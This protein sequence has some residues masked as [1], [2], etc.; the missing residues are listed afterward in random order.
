MPSIK[1][2][3]SFPSVYD[4]FSSMLDDLGLVQMV[5]E[6]I[7]CGN[8]LDLFLTSN[9]SL[10]QKVEFV[11]GIADHDIM[12]ANVNVKPQIAE[13]KPRSVPLYRKA[14][15]YSFRKY[16]SEFASDFMLKYEN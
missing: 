10:V 1:S 8:V 16:I 6:P 7:R 5:R 14:D 11:P 2:G 15:C 4:D 9:H 12:I 13:Q 3:C